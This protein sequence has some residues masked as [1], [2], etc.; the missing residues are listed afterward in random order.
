M[1]ISDLFGLGL[2]R[3]SLLNQ[4]FA[5]SQNYRH[6]QQQHAPMHAHRHSTSSSYNNQVKSIFSYSMIFF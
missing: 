1:A 3:G 5:S 2:P 4:S 6:H